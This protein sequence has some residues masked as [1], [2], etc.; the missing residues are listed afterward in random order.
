MPATAGTCGVVQLHNPRLAHSIDHF[1][2]QEASRSHSAAQHDRTRWFAWLVLAITLVG[3]LLRFTRLGQSYWYDEAVTVGL[4]RSSLVSMLHSLPGSE[5]T[6]PLY[7]G[8][9]WVWSRVFGT[10][11][12]ELRSLSALV[13]TAAIPVAAAAGRELLSK[14]AGVLAGAFVAVSPLLTWYSQEARAYSLYVLLSTLSVWLFARAWMAPSKNRLSWWAVGSALAIWTEY[15]AVFLVIAEALLLT[16]RPSTRRYAKRPMLAIVISMVVLLPLI[17][18]QMH[19]GRNGWIAQRSLHGRVTAAVQSF[20]GSPPHLW[21]VAAAVVALGVV[22]VGVLDTPSERQGAFLMA[23]V[24]SASVLLPLM[25]VAVGKDYWLGRNVIDA[26]VPLAMALAAGLAAQS[27]R[28]LYTRGVL[29]TVSLAIVALLAARSITVVTDAHKRADWR[30]LA[31]CLGQ[32]EPTRAFAISPGYNSVVLKLYRPNI[33]PVTASDLR[34]SELDVI[35]K[36]PGSVPVPSGF[37]RAGKACSATIPVIRLRAR[38][39]LPPPRTPGDSNV[40]IDARS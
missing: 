16:V 23:A 11:E 3:G 12:T 38:Q 22:T 1:V 24:G 7:Y 35:S 25:L 10:T 31:R 27:V 4:V 37:H 15:F 30:G 19:N 36:N 33:R 29:V 6:P 20:I 26:W 21:W 17:Y 39:Q 9:A 2:S 32:P 18:K 28:G 34:V 40:L 8:L 13:G 5:S 14:P